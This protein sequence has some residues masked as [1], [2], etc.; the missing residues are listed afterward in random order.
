MKKSL[1]AVAVLGGF[2]SVAVA[3]SS[4]TLYGRIDQNITYQDP[5]KNAAASS[6]GRLGKVLP[7][8]TMVA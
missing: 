5:G 7:R 6:G 3:Q 1:V 8:S 4:V 2:A